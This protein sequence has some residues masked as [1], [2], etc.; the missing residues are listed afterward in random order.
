MEMYTKKFLLSV[1][2]AG[3]LL[4]SGVMQASAL[5]ARPDVSDNQAEEA[6]SQAPES[7]ITLKELAAIYWPDSHATQLQQEE[8]LKNLLGKKVTW[9]ITVA[10]IQRHGAG[11]LIQGQSSRDM[12]GTFSHVMP[13]TQQEVDALL[14][15]SM[16]SKLEISGMVKDMELR[17]IV[18]DPANVVT[19]K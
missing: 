3:A 18:L 7:H 10:Q 16:G 5:G 14:K 19:T 13:K 9:E 15:A 11:Y 4:L 12:L 2:L 6:M 8:T 17:H 1:L